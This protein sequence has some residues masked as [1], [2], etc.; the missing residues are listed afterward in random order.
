MKHFLG[1]ILLIIHLAGCINNTS[2]TANEA[3]HNA[4]SPQT[5]SISGKLVFEQKCAACHGSDGTAGIANAANLQ[6]SKSDRPS[7][8]QTV[9][10]G[11]NAM[12]SFKS[13]LTEEE[14]LKLANYLYTLRK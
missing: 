5:G 3:A 6:A 8:I 12:P 13:Q 11:K 2:P 1:F 14:I 10:D 9:S 7:V 4:N